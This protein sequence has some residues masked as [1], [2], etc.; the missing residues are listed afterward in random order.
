MTTYG[1]RG[2][3]GETRRPSLSFRYLFAILSLSFCGGTDLLGGVAAAEP[4]T[5]D[6]GRCLDAARRQIIQ[7]SKGAVAGPCRRLALRHAAGIPVSFIGGGSYREWEFS[8]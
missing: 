2:D 8:R 6:C 7:S 1:S 3:R 4:G 5:A